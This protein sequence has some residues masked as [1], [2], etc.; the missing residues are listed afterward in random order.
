M[1]D[2]SPRSKISLAILAMALAA[3]ASV[4]VGLSGANE[5]PSVNT[6]ASGKGHINVHT[7][8]W[9]T[10]WITTTGVKGTAAHLHTGAAGTNGPVA[11]PLVRNDSERSALMVNGDEGWS[12]PHNAR[13]TAAQYESFKKGEVYVNVHS[14][15]NKA[16]EVRGQLKP[17]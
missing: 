14:A 1:N 5:S 4:N 8:G 3:C 6:S 17:Y 15:A 10:G 13:L 12:V 2:L 9:V 16:G 7:D 11:V